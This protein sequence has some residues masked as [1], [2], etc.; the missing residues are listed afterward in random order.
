MLPTQGGPL[1]S[2][3]PGAAQPLLHAFAGAFTPPTFK[4]FITLMLGAV[5]NTGRRTITNL[6]RAVGGLAPGSHRRRGL[7]SSPQTPGR[8]IRE[9]SQPSCEHSHPGA[10]RGQREGDRGRRRHN[11]STWAGGPGGPAR[12]QPG[13]SFER[14]YSR[15]TGDGPSPLLYTRSEGSPVRPKVGPPGPPGPPRA[16][17]GPGTRPPLG[18]GGY[19]YVFTFCRIVRRCSMCGF[20]QI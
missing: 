5:L 12:R 8:V 14:A 7:A 11:V 10:S 6:L 13:E 3:L 2:L 18:W 17:A 20:R 9:C 1:M 19:R 15:C 4:R 16:P